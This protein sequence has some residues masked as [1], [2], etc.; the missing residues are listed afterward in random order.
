MTYVQLSGTLTP[1]L[2]V[3]TFAEQS[4]R[5]KARNGAIEMEERS[6]EDRTQ[7]CERDGACRNGF[8]ARYSWGV[9]IKKLPSMYR[10]ST[11]SNWGDFKGLSF[12]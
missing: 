1:R 2:T 12:I 4:S 3:L 6:A 11:P 7:C 9:D 8:S 10:T 5:Q